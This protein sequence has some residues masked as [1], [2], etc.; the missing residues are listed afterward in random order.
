R[1]GWGSPRAPQAASRRGPDIRAGTH[2]IAQTSP[3]TRLSPRP[4]APDS[5]MFS[6]V[7]ERLLDLALIEDLSAGDATTD[8]LFS[9]A[10]RAHASL[11]AK[12]R[13]VVAGGPVFSHVMRRVAALP[14]AP[15]GPLSLS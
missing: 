12:A 8:A 6:P 9:R 13:M 3:R 1:T 4:F 10:D 15:E 7:F 2:Y 14:G 11:V 5:V